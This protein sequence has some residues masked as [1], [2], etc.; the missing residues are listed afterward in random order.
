M[1]TVKTGLRYTSEHEWI[2]DESPA[3]IGITQ[4][5]AD[6]LGEMVYIELPAV[7]DTITV[8]ETFGE[9]ESTKAVSELFAPVS[10]EV[11]EVNDA[12]VDDPALVNT[13]AYGAWFIKV[14]VSEE[15]TLLSAEEYAA[16]NDVTL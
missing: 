5:A 1:S 14:E 3:A 2:T 10:G 4:I 7:G 8:G 9:V 13:D 15:G 12:V 6:E 11:V 16:E